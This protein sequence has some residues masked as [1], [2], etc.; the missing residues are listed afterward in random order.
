MAEQ[1]KDTYEAKW[2][3]INAELSARLL[4]QDQVLGRIEAKASAVGALALV[5]A[6]VLAANDPFRT[7]WSTLLALLAYVFYGATAVCSLVVNRV[8]RGSDIDGAE[9]ERHARDLEKST[10]HVLQQLIVSKAAAYRDNNEGAEGRA[11]VWLVSL[12]MLSAGF[13]CTVACILLTG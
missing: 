2:E 13:A 4:R 8:A 9:L 3:L 5:A 6:P 11:R 7:G 12:V 10:G 1:D